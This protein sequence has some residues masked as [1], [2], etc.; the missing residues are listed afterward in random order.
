M[1]IAGGVGTLLGPIVGS[2]VLAGVFQLASLYLP[3]IHPLFSGAFIIILALCL[4]S[5][6]MSILRRRAGG[7]TV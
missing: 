4:P 5:G 1:T 6:V 3:R 2:L 7:S